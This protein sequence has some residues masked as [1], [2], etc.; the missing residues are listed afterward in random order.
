VSAPLSLGALAASVRSGERSAV[1]VVSASLEAIAKGD[2]R[3]NAFTE[4]TRPRALAQAARIDAMRAAGEDPGPLAGAPF[5]V[6]NLYDIEGVTTLSGSRIHRD[7]PPAASDAR[8]IERLSSA[9][10]ILVGALNMDEY[11]YGFSTENTHYGATRNP[12]D[13]TRIAGGS[14]GGSA[15]AVAAGLVALTL[16]SDTNGSI[17]VPAALCGIFGL[18]PT[19]GR[20]GRSGM[21][22]FCSSLDVSGPFAASAR[23]LAFAYDVLQGPDPGDPVCARRAPAMTVPELSKGLDGLRIA[24]AG[25]YFQAQGAPE[26]IAAAESLASALGVTARIE[27]PAAGLAR[28]AAMIVTSVEGAE[29]HL[30]D[31]IA[32]A[33]EFD[34]MT[35]SRFLAGALTPGAWYSRAQRFRRWYVAEVARLFQQVDVVLAPATPYPAFPIGQGFTE[36]GGQKLPAAGHLGVYTQP[37][38]FAGLPVVAAPAAGAGALPLGVQIIAAPWREDHAL[39]VAA[40]AEALGACAPFALP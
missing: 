23:D 22:L 35:R 33:G 20:L 34:P 21:R 11:A 4:V 40:F 19:Y 5:A 24:L 31:L 32:R 8:L 3:I 16:G 37:V 28:A 17:R 2:A 29:L 6:K 30:P 9:G 25:G 15:A 14:S 36:I 18:R 1:E 26:A 7:R 12:H 38:S 27:W 39:R 10:A 13:S